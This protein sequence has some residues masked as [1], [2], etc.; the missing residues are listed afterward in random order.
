[1]GAGSAGN[2]PGSGNGRKTV[3]DEGDLR[4]R[5][6]RFQF[7]RRWHIHVH[8]RPYEQ[9]YATH[10]TVVTR[11]PVRPGIYNR[12]RENGLAVHGPTVLLLRAG[13]GFSA[14]TVRIK[15]L[16]VLKN[17]YFF[18][19]PNGRRSV[20]DQCSGVGA[21]IRPRVRFTSPV[22]FAS[23]NNFTSLRSRSGEKPQNKRKPNGGGTSSVKYGLDVWKWKRISSHAMYKRSTGTRF[24]HTVSGRTSLEPRTALVRPLRVVLKRKNSPFYRRKTTQWKR[25]ITCVTR[26]SKTLKWFLEW[27]WKEIV[28][29]YQRS[30]TELHCNVSKKINVW[31]D[32]VRMFLITRH[33][34]KKRR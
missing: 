20:Y 30:D 25:K 14:V 2:F 31:S 27:R 3:R 18:T 12:S 10:D 8:T 17:I 32:M 29:I 5:I 26:I 6:L 34:I 23:R 15:G 13:H 4:K 7:C 9:C 21:R 33:K 19:A 24:G 11:F 28:S 1:M 16:A 22:R